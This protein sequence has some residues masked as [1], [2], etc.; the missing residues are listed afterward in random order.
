MIGATL[1]LYTSLE[2][3]SGVVTL[4]AA[5]Q[6]LVHDPLMVQWVAIAASKRKKS[7]E[8]HHTVSFPILLRS[9][10]DRLPTQ[11]HNLAYNTEDLTFTETGKL[12]SRLYQ[13]RE[14]GPI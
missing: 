13:L 8:L 7:A 11:G 12:P 4:A 6:L 2:K 9:W 10:S 14:Q 1:P 3:E 5:S